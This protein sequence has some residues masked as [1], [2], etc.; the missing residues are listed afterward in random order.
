MEGRP[1]ASSG[2]E[3][4]EVSFVRDAREDVLDALRESAKQ[5]TLL[6]SCEPDVREFMHQLDVCLSS[7][8]EEW[9]ALELSYR[10]QL[11]KKEKEQSTLR[12]AIQER[13]KEIFSLREEVT[14]AQ[15]RNK[16]KDA[17]CSRQVDKL[18][19]ELKRLTQNYEKLKS[20]KRSTTKSDESSLPSD[21]T[22][23]SC[24]LTRLRDQYDLL[25][26]RKKDCD[27]DKERLVSQLSSSRNEVSAL[28]SRCL[29]LQ[30]SVDLMQNK[31]DELT[32]EK[33]KS[34]ELHQ[35][36]VKELETQLDQTQLALAGRD[37]LVRS[38]RCEQEETLKRNKDSLLENKDLVEKV[39][40]LQE[41]LRFAEKRS[42]ELGQHLKM[43]EESLQA[44]TAENAKLS[45][46][47]KTNDATGYRGI[48]KHGSQSC[49]PKAEKQLKQQI[50]TLK[51]QLD[52]LRVECADLKHKLSLQECTSAE[53][54]SQ[55]SVLLGT[56]M[57]HTQPEV[58]ERMREL[59][60]E[61]HRLETLVKQREREIG[62]AV[63]YKRQL[64]A[65][66][67]QVKDQLVQ[68]QQQLKSVFGELEEAKR[69][70]HTLHKG[71]LPPPSGGVHSVKGQNKYNLS[72]SKG[73]KNKSVKNKDRPTKTSSNDFTSED[74]RDTS[75][76]HQSVAVPSGVASKDTK[77]FS[78]VVK[79][80]DKM[81]EDILTKH[82]NRI[83]NNSM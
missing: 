39:C 1:V 59:S 82:F 11:E 74:L 24:E 4:T 48:A 13:E 3:E 14:L 15:K 78:S 63:L 64:E 54:C 2:R 45:T 30:E 70:N 75:R 35:L 23:K 43:K 38:L 68:V 61:N 55:T 77:E 71:G 21:L 80:L 81:L 5:G 26:L 79:T 33:K 20:K 6:A 25:E 72:S 42:K 31:V 16:E 12:I 17:L 19:T 69:I 53:D 50:L 60:L 49:S 37:S 22:H 66:V 7:K 44:L 76:I 51:N 18:K 9:K 32:R 57:H 27:L 65:E 73:G 52:G 29:A 34:V 8:Q 41:K 40:R 83:S 10:L 56:R 47:L 62:E 28:Q 67:D 58:K 36:Q 46:L